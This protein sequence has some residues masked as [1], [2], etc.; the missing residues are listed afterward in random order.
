[1]P[2]FQ[3][4]VPFCRLHLKGERR[5]RKLFRGEVVREG[6]DGIQAYCTFQD[7]VRRE[8]DNFDSSDNPNTN[9]RGTRLPAAEKRVCV[10]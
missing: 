8:V 5:F 4:I 10:V 2:S 3:T 7:P 6:F 9:S 1:M